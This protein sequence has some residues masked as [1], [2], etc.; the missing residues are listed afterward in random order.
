M[1]YLAVPNPLSGGIDG[2][3]S[4]PTAFELAQNYPNPFNAK[5]V[6]AFELKEA[7][8]VKVEVFD[9]T[10]AKVATLANQQMNAGSH[11][12]TWNAKMCHPYLLLQTDHKYSF[13]IEAD[14]SNQVISE[15]FL[16]FLRYG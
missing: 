12:L 1:M 11:Q 6:I 14:G 16:K 13:R 7:S 15:A 9:V 5:T 2:A 10:G 8:P 4:K 3:D